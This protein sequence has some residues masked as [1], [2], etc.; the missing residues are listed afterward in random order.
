MRRVV[1]MLLWVMLAIGVGIVQ[2]ENEI[3]VQS[4]RDTNNNSAVPY[5]H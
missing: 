3:T 5:L 4:I 1:I 2:A